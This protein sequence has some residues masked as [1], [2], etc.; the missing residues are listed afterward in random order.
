MVWDR[1]FYILLKVWNENRLLGVSKL[2]AMMKEISL[3]ATLSHMYVSQM[4]GNHTGR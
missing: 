2:S 3:A 1:P 4:Q